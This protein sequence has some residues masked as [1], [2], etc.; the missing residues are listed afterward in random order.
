M[1]EE[2]P[3]QAQIKE[4]RVGGL[5]HSFEVLYSTEHKMKQINYCNIRE[6]KV[7]KRD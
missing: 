2:L 6:K 1:V 3:P 5:A 7:H 4:V